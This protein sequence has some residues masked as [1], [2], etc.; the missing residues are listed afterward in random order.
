M[1]HL[2]QPKIGAAC[3]I[4]KRQSGQEVQETQHFGRFVPRISNQPLVSPFPGE[5]HFLTAGMNASR[6]LEQ[7]RAG[8]ID[9]RR[10]RGLDQLGI[11]VEHVAGS[12]LLDDRRLRPDVPCHEIGRTEFVEFRSVNT[13]SVG[14]NCRTL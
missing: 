14:V 4:A 8:R 7:S 3:A 1:R 12:E 2:A 9:Y 11:G 5:D 10:L 13:N 6:Q